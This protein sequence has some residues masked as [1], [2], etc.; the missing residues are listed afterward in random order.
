MEDD[1]IPQEW[2]GKRKRG[3][4]MDKN[5]VDLFKIVAKNNGCS[6]SDLAIEGMFDPSSV[7]DKKQ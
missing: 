7:D 2:G 5:E 3:F 6:L 1:D 4:Y